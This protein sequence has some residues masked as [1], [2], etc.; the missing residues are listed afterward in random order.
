MPANTGDSS[1][2]STQLALPAECD[3]AAGA[4]LHEQNLT[5][6][7]Q[8]GKKTDTKVLWDARF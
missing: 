7:A 6:R 8:P 4:A 2:A 1:L 3:K 5:K